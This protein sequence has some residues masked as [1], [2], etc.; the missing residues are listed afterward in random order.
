MGKKFLLTALIFALFCSACG[1]GGN[2]A[3]TEGEKAT[4]TQAGDTESGKITDVEINVISLEICPELTMARLTY[5][6]RVLKEMRHPETYAGEF[7][8]ACWDLANSASGELV[9]GAY[10]YAITG[11]YRWTEDEMEKIGAGSF[12]SMGRGKKVAASH[13]KND[14]M[15][16]TRVP[17]KEFEAADGSGITMTVKLCPLGG[18]IESDMEWQENRRIAYIIADLKDGSSEYLT[19][20]PYVFWGKDRKKYQVEPPEEVQK[21]ED[22]E[23]EECIIHN[24]GGAMPD[25]QTYYFHTNDPADVDA[26]AGFRLI[27]QELE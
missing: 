8:A 21:L 13:V 25:Y 14:E 3:P 4:E 11:S 20:L 22:K 23:Y 15:E 12:G 17:M 26:I 9:D 27:I 24:S 10:R 7:G 2:T 18:R 19:K 1:I 5:D 6:V 16:I